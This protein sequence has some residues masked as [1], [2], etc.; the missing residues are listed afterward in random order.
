MIGGLFRRRNAQE[1]TATRDV[2]HRLTPQNLP[3][4]DALEIAR[5]RLAIG[6]A[7]FGVLFVAVGLRMAYVSLLRDGGEPGVARA[8]HPAQ[9]QADRADILDRN[10][11]VLATSLP[12]VSL[13]A[14]PRLVLDVEEAAVKLSKTLPD[15]KAED[16]REKLLSGRSFVWIKRGLSPREHAAV[17]RLGL[18]GFEFQAEERRIYP[19]GAI[20][21]HVLGYTGIDNVGLAGVEKRFDETLRQGEALRLSIDIRLQ[22]FLEQ[23][24]ARATQRFSAIGATAAVMDVSTGEILGMASLPAYDPNRHQ[25]ISNEALFNRSTLGVYEQGSTFKIFN[26][27]MALDSG[28]FSP[29]SVFDASAPLKVDRFTITDYHGQYRPLTIAEIFKYSSNIGSAKMAVE[30]GVEGQRSFMEKIGMLRPVPIELPEVGQPLYPKHWRKISML[31]IAYGHGISVTPMHVV[32]GASAMINGGI[33]YPPTLVKRGV[34]NHP[35]AGRRVISEKTSRQMRDLF[36]L[37]VV[38]GSGKNSEVPGFEVGGKT[39]SA[40]KPGRHGYREK[41][42]ISSF[43]AAF[44][45]RDPKYVVMVSIDEPK[46]T[47]ETGGYATGGAVAAPSTRAIIEFMATLYGITPVDPAAAA[48]LMAAAPTAPAPATATPAATAPATTVAAAPAPSSPAAKPASAPAA[49]PA[50]GLSLTQLV[51]ATTGG[52]SAPATGGG[53]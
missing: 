33:Y 12:V 10:G 8:A 9:V 13:F 40:E 43:V 31:T 50:G 52:S 6:A 29:T 1:A 25:T 45:M 53:R 27:A 34:G 51:D 47:K 21:P 18:P 26:T 20:G 36:R 2:R 44:P 37:N 46:G 5:G 42:L 48:K 15:I 16:V 14:T 22:R 3:A 39:G 28:R 30:I 38:E 17:M 35:D 49:K 11:V 24:I 4:R 23:E 19:Q 41:A 7:L 32:A